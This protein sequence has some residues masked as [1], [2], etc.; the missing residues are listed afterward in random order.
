MES[1]SHAPVH[2]DF[3]SFPSTA[4]LKSGFQWEAEEF[5]TIRWR[6]KMDKCLIT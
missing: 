3:G 2:Q 6:V 1:V 4:L 5:D